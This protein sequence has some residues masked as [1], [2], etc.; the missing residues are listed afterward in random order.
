MSQIRFVEYEKD[1]CMLTRDKID[2]DKYYCVIVTDNNGN[3]TCLHQEKNVANFSYNPQLRVDNP[4]YS[5][6]WNINLVEECES[7]NNNEDCCSAERI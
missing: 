1:I 6:A 2:G 4:L 7:E 3:T 5:D